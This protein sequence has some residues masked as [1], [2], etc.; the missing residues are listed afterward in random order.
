MYRDRELIV[1]IEKDYK[2]DDVVNGW[3]EL[4]AGIVKSSSRPRER[5]CQL[6]CRPRHHRS[7]RLRD[8]S[9]IALMFRRAGVA[10]LADWKYTRIYNPQRRLRVFVEKCRKDSSHLSL[11]DNTRGKPLYGFWYSW[12]VPSLNDKKHL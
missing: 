12:I 8:S 11:P 9:P 2:K 6:E 10:N 1:G 3:S 5:M 4:G 7:L